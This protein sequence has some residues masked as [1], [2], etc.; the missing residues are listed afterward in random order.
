MNVPSQYG[1]ITPLKNITALDR[2]LTVQYGVADSLLKQYRKNTNGK[3]DLGFY[4]ALDSFHVRLNRN[5]TFLTL[6]YYL[7]LPWFKEWFWYR[8]GDLKLNP[9]DF[10]SDNVIKNNPKSDLKKAGIYNRYIDSL[11]ERY[12]QYDT[13]QKIAEF[14]TILKEKDN[15]NDVFSLPDLSDSLNKINDSMKNSLL[16][17]DIT[18]NKVSIPT[19]G[20]F[21]NFSAV[22]DITFPNNIKHIKNEYGYVKNNDK[23]LKMAVR[24]DETKV[25]IIHNIKGTIKVGITESNTPI[26]DRSSF[27]SG[28]DTVISQLGQLAAIVAKFTPYASWLNLIAVPSQQYASPTREYNKK[29]LVAKTADSVFDDSILLSNFINSSS[30]A[31]EPLQG[32]TDNNPMYSSKIVETQTSDDP[33]KKNVGVF[34]YASVTDT[35]WIKKFSYKIGK[36]YRFQLGS[37]IAYTLN[38]YN[39]SVVSPNN[40]QI[41]ITNNIQQYRFIVSLHTYLIKG[42][43]LQDDR[44]LGRF[45]ERLSLTTGVGIPDPLGNV[46]IGLSYDPWPG[47]KFTCGYHLDRNDNYL[48][49]NNTIVE[50]QLRYKVAGNFIS[51]E[52]RPN[53]FY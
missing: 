47:L 3:F 26:I 1:K 24:T 2:Y 11:I 18:L 14:K 42:L 12:I 39:Q 36:N 33:V 37:G 40:G 19:Q 5:D 52:N 9:L 7:T 29:V 35:T 8:G 15:G 31:T 30:P 10:T 25:I 22:T 32:K 49:Q 53:K 21:Y 17:T 43:F 44:V 27:Q 41:T 16:I 51:L 46:Y 13:V 50:Q 28:T 23:Y 34:Y 4:N 6:K 48:I 20:R 45:S 38:P